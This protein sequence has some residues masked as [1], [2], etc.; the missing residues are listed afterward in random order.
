MNVRSYFHVGLSHLLITG[1]TVSILLFVGGCSEES[2]TGIVCENGGVCEEGD[3]QCPE[4]F[5]G[6]NCEVALDPCLNQEC[7]NG[8]CETTSANE[9]VCICDEGY[10]GAS[11]DISWSNRFLGDWV[12]VE[13]CNSMSMTFAAP[14]VDGPRF[15][16]FTIENFHNAVSPTSGAKVVATLLSPTSFEIQPQFMEFGRV[17]GQ[18]LLREDDQ[19]IIFSYEIA[20]PSDTLDCVATFSRP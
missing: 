13:S 14:I 20:T 5:F 7:G 9:A 3:C 1:L 18:G 16:R 2:C 6:A 15:Q 8:R 10:E 19:Q 4:G 12:A 11:C 17:S